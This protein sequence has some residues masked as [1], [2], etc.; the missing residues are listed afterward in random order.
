MH[1]TKACP[2]SVSAKMAAFV[3]A[4]LTWFLLFLCGAS[5]SVSLA[6]MADKTRG[7]KGLSVNDVLSRLLLLPGQNDG[8]LSDEE[9]PNGWDMNDGGWDATRQ[10]TVNLVKAVIV[11][12]QLLRAHVCS[13]LTYPKRLPFVYVLFDLFWIISLIGVLSCSWRTTFFFKFSTK[14]S[15]YI[16]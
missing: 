13:W 15:R 11:C 7:R 8:N 3:W 5:R 4:I 9:H 6:K 12:Q 2:L 1:V 14:S 10:V 16:N